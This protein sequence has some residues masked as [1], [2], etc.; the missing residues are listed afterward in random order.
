ML[1]GSLAFAVMGSLAHTL[2]ASYGWQV[3]A[4]ARTVLPL[5]L[6]SLFGLAV[7]VRF[8]YVRPRTL[9]L[10]SLAGSVSMMATFYALT[11]LPVSDVF[12][13]TN[14]FPIWVALL[15]WPLLNEPP[16]SGVWAAVASGVV[17]VALIQQ[18]H[19]AE[20]NPTCLVALS[21]S[22]FTAFAMIGLHRLSG[23]DTLAIVA[24][25]SAVALAVCVGCLF[26]FDRAP[27]PT[28]V[29]AGASLWCLLGV[30]LSA[31]VGQVF[32]TKAFAAGAPA[33][34]SVVGLMQIVFA[35]GIDAAWWH[36]SFNLLTLL[37]M[38]LVL[39]PTA[40]VM[41]RRPAEA[42]IQPLRL[43]CATAVNAED[44]PGGLDGHRG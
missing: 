14:M 32:L 29:P 13:L 11:R 34:V 27:L 44:V 33:K 16:S 7:G 15:A 39:A 40:W 4:L 23:I 31:T 38:G 1:C 21:A 28:Q 2:G 35:V 22:V 8:V 6:V 24:H 42:P 5:L 19:L 37:G 10:R 36:R 12:T 20:G 9:W 26:A 18:P 30:G 43:R 17:G 3:I 41:L 25:F